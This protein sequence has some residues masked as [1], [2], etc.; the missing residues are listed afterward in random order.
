[1]QLY[2]FLITLDVFL[3]EWAVGYAYATHSAFDNTYPLFRDSAY[4]FAA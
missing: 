1:M 4:G 3:R 2:L